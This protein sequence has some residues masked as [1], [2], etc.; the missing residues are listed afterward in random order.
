MNNYFRLIH[1]RHCYIWIAHV[2]NLSKKGSV[3][4]LAL[5]RNKIQVI[6]NVNSFKCFAA[7]VKAQ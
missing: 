5:K 7:V 1:G 4:P 6:P 3:L 2:F